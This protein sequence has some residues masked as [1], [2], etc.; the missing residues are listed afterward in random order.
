MSHYID[1]KQTPHWGPA[2]LSGRQLLEIITGV[3]V[4]VALGVAAFAYVNTAEPIASSSTAV[5]SAPLTIVAHSALDP[6]ETQNVSPRLHTTIGTGS[7][8][9]TMV[10]HSALDPFET[11]NVSPR[12][13]ATIGASAGTAPLTMVTHSA[14][15]PVETQNVSPRGDPGAGAPSQ[16][17]EEGSSNALPEFR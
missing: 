1:T 11:Q 16:P 12:L 15:D 7:A 10:T 9:L 6:F 2:R 17:A 3:V 14:L 4:V 8:P 5:R 13:Q